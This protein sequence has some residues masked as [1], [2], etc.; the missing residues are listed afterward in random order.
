M[1]VLRHKRLGYSVNESIA[2][3]VD[4]LSR[5]AVG[6]WR[7][8]NEGR[9][10]FGLQGDQLVDFVRGHVIALLENGAKPVIGAADQRF[11][12]E[13]VPGYGE[14]PNQIASGIVQEWLASGRDPDF[15]SVWFALPRVYES[16]RRIDIP[17]ETE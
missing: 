10:G 16:R 3:D 1:K 7:I 14:S 2:A 11:S 4:E 8:V 5:D 6:L 17:R 13:M 15:G 9:L 12:W